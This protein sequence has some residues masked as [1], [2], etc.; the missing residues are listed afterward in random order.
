MRDYDFF[1]NLSN[2]L[3]SIFSAPP[4]D[5]PEVDIVNEVLEDN[6]DVLEVVINQLPTIYKFSV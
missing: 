1:E 3:E 5:Y 2:H 4:M 6:Q